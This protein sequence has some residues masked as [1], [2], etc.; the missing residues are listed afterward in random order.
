MATPVDARLN[1]IKNINFESVFRPAKRSSETSDDVTE[2]IELSKLEPSAAPRADAELKGL[3][4]SSRPVV[5]R[6]LI[7]TP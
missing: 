7:R 5:N 2:K 3:T 1:A 6:T 4:R